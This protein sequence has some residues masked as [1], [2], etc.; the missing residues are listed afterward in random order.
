VGVTDVVAGDRLF[1]ADV[2]HL[3]HTGIQSMR[4]EVIK[5]AKKTIPRNSVLKFSRLFRTMTK[6]KK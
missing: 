2:A 3:R 5:I 6:W 1:S 4:I